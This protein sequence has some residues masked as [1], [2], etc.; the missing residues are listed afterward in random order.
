MEDEEI[1]AKRFKSNSLD[2]VLEI[3]STFTGP[4]PPSSSYLPVIKQE[5][6]VDEH[7]RPVERLEDRYSHILVKEKLVDVDDG[8]NALVGDSFGR[9]S[10]DTCDDTNNEDGVVVERYYYWIS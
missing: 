7:G 2:E 5:M 9:P 10:E 6:E 8:I 4:A 3:F 1:S